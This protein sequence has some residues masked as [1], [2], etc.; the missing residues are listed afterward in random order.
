MATNYAQGIFTP[1]HPEKYMGKNSI[2]YRSSWELMF[3]HFCDN[4]PAIVG[5]ASEAIFIPYVNPLSGKSSSYCPDFIIQYVDKNGQRHSELIEIKPGKEVALENAKSMRDKAMVAVNLAKWQ[6][7]TAWAKKQG[8]K[9]RV[10][11][12]KDIFHQGSKR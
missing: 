1:K 4:N 3:M 8:I 6:A 2:K 12:E 10:I 5:W 9:F 11:T 7:A